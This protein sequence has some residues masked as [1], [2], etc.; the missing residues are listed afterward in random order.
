[1][2]ELIF[3]V[4]VSHLFRNRDPRSPAWQGR[5][6]TTLAALTITLVFIYHYAPVRSAHAIGPTVA[7]DQLL[8]AHARGELVNGQPDQQAITAA[9]TK[10]HD[11]TARL[12]EAQASDQAQSILFPV[13]EALGGELALEGGLAL[14]TM[15]RQRRLKRDVKDAQQEVD[16][17]TLAINVAT[18]RDVSEVVEQLT[19]AGHRGVSRWVDRANGRRMSAP[20]SLPSPAHPPTTPDETQPRN[21]TDV[22]PPQPDRVPHQPINLNELHHDRRG[23]GNPSK[24]DLGA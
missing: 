4:L 14:I 21:P 13:G 3:A 24:W 18:H 23:A 22:P 10:L 6:W 15:Q 12:Q 17:H 5:M 19:D 20:R 1:M 16:D 8:A 7:Q 2:L 9:D 11:D